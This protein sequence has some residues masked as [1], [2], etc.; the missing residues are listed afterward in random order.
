MDTNKKCCC[1]KAD[2][3]KPGVAIDIAD[4]DKVTRNEVDE[5]TRTLDDNPESE[6]LFDDSA[7]EK[8]LR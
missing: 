2:R 8:T 4:N 6:P 1:K 7:H 3:T 5:R